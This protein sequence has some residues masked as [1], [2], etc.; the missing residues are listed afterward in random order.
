MTEAERAHAREYHARRVKD[1][2]EYRERRRQYAATQ[3]SKRTIE[4]RRAAEARRPTRRRNLAQRVRATELARQ[5]RRQHTPEQRA[6]Y[7]NLKRMHQRSRR[8]R[9]RGL[10]IEHVNPA[11]VYKMHDGYCGICKQFIEGDFHV[12]HIIPLSKDGP[13]S[14]ANTQPAHPTCNL[15][16][17]ATYE[18][19]S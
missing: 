1:D 16:K 15:R 13:H 18:P 4:Q 3:N 7:L 12:D 17:S 2:P 14:Y 11:E 6:Y 5:R 19:Q 9:Q 10:F 8:A